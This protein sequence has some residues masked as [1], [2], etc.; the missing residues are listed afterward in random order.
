MERIKFNLE[1][2]NDIKN[3]N[4]VFKENGFKLFIVGGAIRDAL[5]NET[6][7]DFDLVTDA[8]PDKVEEM[9]HASGFETI[10][11]GK[12]FGVINVFT[13]SS[14]FEIAT[15]RKDIG[16]DGRRPEHVEFTTIEE[17]ILR[18]DL[19]INALFFDLD[20]SEVVDMVGGVEDLKNGIIRTVGDASERFEEDRLRI[21]RAA[22][23]SARFDAKLSTDIKIS[24]IQDNNL[25]GIS[26]ER[27]RDEFLKGIKSAKSVIK[28]MELLDGFDL[29]DWIFPNMVVNKKFIEDKDHIVVLATLLKNH[30]L[31][32]LKKDLNRLTYPTA[33]IKA[34]EFLTSLH[35]LD[36]D[37]AVH[38]KNSFKS[39]GVSSDQL[40]N[41]GSREC[42]ASQLLDAFEEFELTVDGEDVMKEFNLKPSK[43]LG[44]KIREL[45]TN[46][47]KKLLGM[48]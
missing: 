41:F 7:K 37:T 18:R 15:M 24:L 10:A 14:E 43:E 46:N 34:I 23:F 20:T 22:R 40:R 38:F 36:I 25:N 27:I 30:E 17:D 32:N 13:D 47:F 2:P 45:E 39:S 11:T 8:I 12:A 35:M 31:S 6:P 3:I 42:I 9:M 4:Q 48:S 21:L 16:S 5:L 28:F 44:D 33:E 1:I 26:G 29:F 19:T